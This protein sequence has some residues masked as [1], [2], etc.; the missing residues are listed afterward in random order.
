MA[1]EQQKS[2]EGKLKVITSLS[3]LTLDG[4]AV[5][6]DYAEDPFSY[7]APPPGEQIYKFKLFPDKEVLKSGLEDPKNPK[8]IYIMINMLAKIIE[9]E[10][11]GAFVYHS[12]STR[13]F[14][15]RNIST[16]MGLLV[17]LLKD[18]SKLPTN[19]TPKQ[20]AT[21][22]MQLL[23]KE[24]VI[25]GELDWQGQYSYVDKSG[26]TKYERVF[27]S[28]SAFPNDPEGGKKH[29]VDV[30]NKYTGGTSTV[31]ARTKITRFLGA[32]EEA[33]KKKTLGVPGGVSAPMGDTPLL[34]QDDAPTL[35][36]SPASAS[37]TIV[38]ASAVPDDD[39]LA[40]MLA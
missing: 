20:Q 29:E 13:V 8:S 34:L 36:S 3:E 7:A 11:E 26:E 23:G 32:N 5:G 35:V 21:Y 17:R 31:I 30:A 18:P 38:A 33:P 12:V 4:D 19:L 2:D 14:R 40:L 10:H 39:S 27:K 15:G 1:N 25:R 9:G 37:P 6:L 28:Y 16:M 24:P 22:F